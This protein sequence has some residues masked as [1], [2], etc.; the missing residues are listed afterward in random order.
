MGSRYYMNKH[1]YSKIIEI[2]S[3]K[4][5]LEELDMT[6]EERNHINRLIDAS[7]HNTILDLILS[8]LSEEDKRIFIDHLIEENHDKIW[9][10]LNKNISDVETKIK[11]AAD[12]LSRELSK[13]INSTDGGE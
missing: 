2:E 3:I 4:L 6:P 8:E 7:L 10:H 9:Q 11:K 12:E 1:F 13:D 5:K